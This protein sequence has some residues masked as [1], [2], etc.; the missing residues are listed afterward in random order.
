NVFVPM[1]TSEMADHAFMLAQ[2]GLAPANVAIKIGA[3]DAAH[4]EQLLALAECCPAVAEEVDAGRL[5]LSECAALAKCPPDEQERR[6]K[7]KV[8]AP[9]GANGKG[10]AA[11]RDE[12]APARLKSKP[13]RFMLALQA[14][15][16]SA[17]PEAEQDAPRF[18]AAEVSALVRAL[19]GDEED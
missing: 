17:V 19:A 12:A 7:R 11:A 5:A 14:E 10:A 3:H 15:V 1:K 4:V 18:S 16:L 6:V 13:G 8:A 9:K 2:K